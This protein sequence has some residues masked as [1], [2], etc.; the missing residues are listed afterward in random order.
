MAKRPTPDTPLQGA[1]D[2]TASR[3]TREYTMLIARSREDR[4]RPG[5][6]AWLG[7]NFPMWDWFRREAD[8]VRAR[9]RKHYAARTIAEYMRH[10]TLLHQREG[11]FKLN[12]HITPDLARLYLLLTPEAEGFFELRGRA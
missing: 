10:Y 3:V 7:D 8:A 5:F 6:V 12:D 9:G 1:L 2:F 4:F 11:D